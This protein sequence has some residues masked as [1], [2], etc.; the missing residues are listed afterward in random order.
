MC[1]EEPGEGGVQSSLFRRNLSTETTPCDP[2]L[3]RVSL[4]LGNTTGAQPYSGSHADTSRISVM[5]RQTSVVGHTL[6][7][8]E[9]ANRL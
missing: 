9:R 8:R 3:G 4:A 2:T 7:R 6:A 1:A 5:N